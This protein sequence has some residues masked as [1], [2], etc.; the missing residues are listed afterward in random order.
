MVSGIGVETGT[1][2]IMKCWTMSCLPPLCI[3]LALSVGRT[4]DVPKVQMVLLPTGA[5]KTVGQYRLQLVTL[6]AEKP[7]ELRKFPAVAAPL[8]GSIKFGGKSYLVVIIDEA[9]GKDA[10]IC[11]DANRNGDLT[12]DPRVGWRK[13][14]YAPNVLT[15]KMAH[16][17]PWYVQAPFER[18][19]KACPGVA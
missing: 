6:S 14:D 1:M 10:A 16:V 7:P 4:D 13:T 5:A 2:G 11:V 3:A 15:G 9:E 18:R 8:H 12:D 19:R 17:L